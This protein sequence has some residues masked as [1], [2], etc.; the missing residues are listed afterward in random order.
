MTSQ[1]TRRTFSPN[2][3]Q[4]P[5]LLLGALM[6]MG[7]AAYTVAEDWNPLTV[8]DVEAF[9]DDA[10]PRFSSR[11][12][13]I[14]HGPGGASL[15]WARFGPRFDDQPPGS[16]LG[17][18]YHHFHEWAL[19]LEGDY[20]IHEPVSP[21]QK[22]GP[23]YQ[24]VEGTWLDR[25]AYSIHGG[26]WALGGMRSQMPCIMLLFEEGDGS[27]VTI[28]PD[29][30]HF[31]PDFPDKPA[32]YRPDWESVEAFTHPWIVDS[33]TQLEWERDDEDPSRWVKWLS[34]DTEQGFRSR[35]IKVPPGWSSESSTT[36]TWYESANR[37]LYLT[38]GDLRVQRYDADGEPTELVDATK[39]WFIHQ[40]PRALMSHGSGAAT[41]GGAIWLEV[42]YAKSVTLGEGPIEAPKT[43]P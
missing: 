4:A 33:G 8:V 21:R 3:K 6:T 30:D 5:A 7:A 29:G 20:V 37:F 26:T 43:L 11:S 19:I 25:P 34:D 28:G 15:I 27:V 38:W 10:Q 23:L 36:P 13:S 35:L 18:H 39:D 9:P 32:P 40:P 31:K 2:L 41:D 24:F 1:Q 12:K 22:H 14:Y 42:T 17:R 16:A